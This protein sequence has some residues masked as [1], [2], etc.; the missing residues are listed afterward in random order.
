MNTQPTINVDKIVEAPETEYPNDVRAK[1]LHTLSIFPIISPSMLQIG[2]GYPAAHWRPILRQL[3]NEELVTED[4][5]VT[6]TP[7]GR[8]QT[9]TLLSLK[10]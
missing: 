10:R 9:Y 5:L 8:H 7:G 1:I 2:L 3:I 6:P 4:M